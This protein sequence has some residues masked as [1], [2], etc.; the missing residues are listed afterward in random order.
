[1]PDLIY[2]FDTSGRH[3]GDHPATPAEAIAQLEAGNKEFSRLL[4]PVGTGEPE[5]R[6]LRFDADDLGLPRA[7]GTAPIQRPFAAVLGCSD[8]RVPTEMVLGQ[9]CN[10]LFVVRV[11]GNVPGAECL[12]SIDYALT[13]LGESIKIVVVLGHSVC[14]AVSAAVD[15]FL[16]PSRYLDLASSHPLRAVVDRIAVPVRA[17]AKALEEVHGPQVSRASGY[18]AALIEASVP[19]NAALTAA[20]LR[21]EFRQHLGP[22]RQVVYGV[23]N[24]VS[25]RVK[26]PLEEE[27]RVSIRL[28][29]PP[30]DAAGLEQLALVVASGETVRALLG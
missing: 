22:D 26:L 23:Y 27:G 9:A 15:V 11:A 21:H 28:V 24:L 18:R 2:H 4:F 8:A 19:I 12:G 25:R 30:T 20:T 10:D 6:V 17:A 29:P 5:P 3:V 14:G 1:M 16:D 13:A 7:D